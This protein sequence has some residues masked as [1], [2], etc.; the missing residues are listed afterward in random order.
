MRRVS[1]LGAFEIQAETEPPMRDG[2]ILGSRREQLGFV[3][4]TSRESIE[5]IVALVAPPRPG[6]PRRLTATLGEALEDLGC[7][8]VR[9]EL[10]P[11]PTAPE[12]HK[13]GYGAYVQ[14]HLVFRP[15]GRKARR[16]S[17]TAT[18]AIQVAL[19]EGLPMLAESSLLQLDVAQL[20]QDMDRMQDAH[21]RDARKFQSF[22]SRVTATDFQRFYED[23]LQ[24]GPKAPPADDQDDPDADALDE[25]HLD[26]E[27][28]GEVNGD[29]EGDDAPG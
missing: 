21:V 12:D 5:H 14:G 19:R 24:R 18:E 27:V 4:E 17:L 9:V 20:L 2:L 11:L 7:Q 10:I 8:L 3:I 25:A 1:L 26:G 16:I 28:D 29:D 6:M 23:Q 15:E 22:V 13:E